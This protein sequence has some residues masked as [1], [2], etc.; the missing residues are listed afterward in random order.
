MNSGSPSR[1][2]GLRQGQFG[3]CFKAIQ[4]VKVRCS[5]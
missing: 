4:C 3:V 5:C 2:V 1:P